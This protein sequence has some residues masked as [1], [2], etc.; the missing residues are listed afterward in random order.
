MPDPATM[1][2]EVTYASD[3]ITRR[4][5]FAGDFRYHNARIVVGRGLTGQTC[6]IEPREHD[7]AVFYSW[8]LLRIIPSRPQRQN[9]LIQKHHRL[10]P[11]SLQHLLPMSLH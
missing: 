8:K 7:I 5:S 9:H 10:L 4:V 6:R 1:P 11:M 3:A 2:G